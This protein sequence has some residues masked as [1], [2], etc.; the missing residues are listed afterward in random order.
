VFSKSFIILGFIG[1]RGYTMEGV[2]RLV[3]MGA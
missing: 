1:V 2:R 3:C